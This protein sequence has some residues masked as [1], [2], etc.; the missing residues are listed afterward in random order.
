MKALTIKQ[1]WAWMII[2]GGKTIENRT[3]NTGYRGPLLIHASARC[4]LDEIYE[5]KIFVQRA[6]GAEAAAALPHFQRGAYA[7]GGIIGSVDLVDVVPPWK[8]PHN[9]W[10][11][12]GH[13]GFVLAEP[14]SLPFRAC[15]G[16]LSLWGDW[17]IVDGRA[18]P[19]DL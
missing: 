1:P 17:S 7:L 12:P 13:F 3:W 4:T 18:L 9:A 15:K 6:F 5:G 16:Q 14:K 8:A 10:H 2:H 11:V 19:E